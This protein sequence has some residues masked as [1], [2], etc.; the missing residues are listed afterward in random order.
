MGK[1]TFVVLSA[2]L[3]TGTAAS[4]AGIPPQL[5]NKTITTSFAVT[6]PAKRPDGSSLQARRNVSRIIYISGAGRIFSRV[7]R[8]AGGVSDSKDNAPDRTASAFRFDGSNL[9]ATVLLGTG[10]SQ[11]IVSFDSGFQSCTSRVVTGAESGKALVWKGMDGTTYTATGP[12]TAS[13]PSCSMQSGN[14]FAGQ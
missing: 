6:I 10:A 3:L 14:A 12:A 9:V 5:Q 11:M 2:L 7:G 13:S 4:A 1:G 8:Q